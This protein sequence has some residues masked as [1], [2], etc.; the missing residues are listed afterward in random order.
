MTLHSR[1]STVPLHDLH[2]MLSFT[3][4]KSIVTRRQQH[5]QQPALSVTA[6]NPSFTL[7]PGKQAA[8]YLSLLHREAGLICFQWVTSLQQLDGNMPLHYHCSR[9]HRHTHTHIG[10]LAYT[11]SVAKVDTH[12]HS[13]CLSLSLPSPLL[14]G[15]SLPYWFVAVISCFVVALKLVSSH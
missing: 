14:S 8:L 7:P 4:S 12:T 2:P 6:G 11:S 13:L 10:T 5:Q 1:F 3:H 9:V 15:L